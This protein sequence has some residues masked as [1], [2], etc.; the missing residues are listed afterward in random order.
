MLLLQHNGFHSGLI[1]YIE[2][3]NMVNCISKSG[4]NDECNLLKCLCLKTNL[5]RVLTRILKTGF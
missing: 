3:L 1:E 2:K 4:M 5:H